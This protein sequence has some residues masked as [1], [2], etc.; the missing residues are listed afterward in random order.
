MVIAAGRR[1]PAARSSRNRRR[2]RWRAAAS[3]QRSFCSGVPY[4]REFGIAGIGRLGAETVGPKRE[5]PK[6]RS[7]VPVSPGH[8]PGRRVP[9]PDGR[10][11][12]CAPGPRLQRAYQFL[13]QGIVDVEG[14]PA[15]GPAADL[16]AHERSIQSISFW[17][18]GSVSKPSCMTLLPSV[19]MVGGAASTAPG[20]GRSHCRLR[21]C[22]SRACFSRVGPRPAMAPRADFC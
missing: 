12:A 13:E 3:R 6:S 7:S 8:S 5:R 16:L 14:A 19:E 17:K 4:G 10:P 9:A 1:R 2:C 18:S 21:D 15:R 22:L 20:C 11:R